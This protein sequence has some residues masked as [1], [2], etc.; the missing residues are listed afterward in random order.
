[1]SESKDK[2]PVV[3]PKSKILL[4]DCDENFS[5][6]VVVSSI[7][8][9]PNARSHTLLHWLTPPKNLFVVFKIND[10]EIAKEV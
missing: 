3:H 7:R 2:K 5:D 10:E 6:E 1:M 8:V 9:L 4:A